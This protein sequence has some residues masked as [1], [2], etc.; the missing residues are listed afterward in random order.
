MNAFQNGYR[1]LFQNETERNGSKATGHALSSLVRGPGLEETGARANFY[2]L[3]FIIECTTSLGSLLV[4]FGQ[5]FLA[6]GDLKTR[7]T[8][9]A[10]SIDLSIYKLIHVRAKPGGT[11]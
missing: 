3:R 7:L 4:A 10:R 6:S 1:E 11:G 5:S 2:F 8:L 9:R